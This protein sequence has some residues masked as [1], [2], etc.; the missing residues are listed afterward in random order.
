MKG[1]SQRACS[2]FFG[3]SLVVP[4]APPGVLRELPTTSPASQ[5]ELARGWGGRVHGGGGGGTVLPV[6]LLGGG[7]HGE[8]RGRRH[9]RD[10]LQLCPGACAGEDGAEGGAIARV[11][12]AAAEPRCGA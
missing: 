1:A 5:Q 7:R 3:S 11:T 10:R 9:D 12:E 6:V 8:Q 2:S 4:L